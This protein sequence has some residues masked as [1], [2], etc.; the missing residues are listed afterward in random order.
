MA[1]RIQ[2][3]KE[4]ERAVA[5]GLIRLIAAEMGLKQIAYITGL[6]VKTIEY[7]WAKARVIFG[8]SSYVGA[9]KLAIQQGWIIL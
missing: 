2:R 8:V 6:S 7:H 9:T 4:Q 1:C 5:I 3:G